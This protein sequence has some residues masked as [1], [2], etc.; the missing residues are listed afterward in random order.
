MADRSPLRRWKRFF[1]AF[2]AIDAAIESALGC[3]RDKYR[4]VRGDLVEKLCDAGHDGGAERADEGLCLLL[5]QTMVEA[6]QTLRLVPVTPTM[7]TSTDVAKAVA[8]LRGHESE[9][10][11]GLA[12]RVF[13]GWRASIEGDLARVRAA[14]ETLSRIPQEDETVPVSAPPS[15]GDA[16]SGREP[17]VLVANVKQA[18]MIPGPERPKK[19]PPGVCGAG[20]DRVRG[21]KSEDAKR[22]HTVGYCREAEDV[23]R[24]RKVPEMVEQ[25]ST[26][27]HPTIK[28]RSRAS[29][30]GSRDERR[31]SCRGANAQ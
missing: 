26:K 14:L 17:T 22:K 10:V 25:R 4:R 20:G 19:M 24:H 8:G 13:D 21:E 11:R 29:C 12:R 27:A 16:R 31:L 5:D 2:G 28:E 1:P 7:L 9:R 18:A 30:W 6:L 3:S 15:A 23:K